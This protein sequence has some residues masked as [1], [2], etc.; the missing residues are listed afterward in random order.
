MNYS[1]ASWFAY[2]SLRFGA[3]LTALLVVNFSP[4][5]ADTVPHNDVIVELAELLRPENKG[6][7]V[8][9]NQCV[10]RIKKPLNSECAN[11]HMNKSTSTLVDLSEVDEISIAD[12]RGMKAVKIQLDVP[13][14]S[15]AKTLLKRLT[16]GDDAAFEEYLKERD[17]LFEA[18]RLKSGISLTKCSGTES[19]RTSRTIRIF[20]A[21]TPPSWNQLEAAVEACN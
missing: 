10:L 16:K 13:N 3:T 4:A 9:L 21:D 14:P 19:F 12:D 8:T 20:L 15:R 11:P 1:W 5:S 6:V 17:R 18:A 2:R 7:E